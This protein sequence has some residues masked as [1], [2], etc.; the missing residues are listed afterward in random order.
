MRVQIFVDGGNFHYLAL[1]PL[2][3]Q[4]ADFDFDAF[5]EFLADGRTIVEMG[6]RYYIGTVRE[7][8]GDERSKRAMAQQV[9]LFNELKK[10]SWQIK[11]SKLRERTERIVIDWRVVDFQAIRKKGVDEIVYRTFREK[12]IDVKIATDLVAAAL[13]DRCDSVI[14]VSSDADL[15][16]MIDWVR[17][18]LKKKVE[19]VGFSIPSASGGKKRRETNAGLDEPDRRV[20]YF[21][22]TRHSEV[23]EA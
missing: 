5:A 13:D 12:G 14:I 4:E 6:K 11:T 23:L 2:G 10:T 20:S 18:R 7:R 21:N 1:K 16:P 19:Y 22:G 8:E 15:V 17:F 3:I 9:R